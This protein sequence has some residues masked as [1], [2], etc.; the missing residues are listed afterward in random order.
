M[1]ATARC[2]NPHSYHG[3]ETF[4]LLL[5]TKCGLYHGSMDDDDDSDD[6]N[7]DIHYDAEIEQWAAGRQR[8]RDEQMRKIETN[9]RT[10]TTLKINSGRTENYWMELGP[11]IGRNTQLTNIIVKNIPAID[12]RNFARS[13]VLNR[14]IQRLSIAGWDHSDRE[15]WDHL[16]RFFIDNEACK[17]LDLELRC[18]VGRSDE[19][20]SALRRFHSLKEV[21]LS[22]FSHTSRNNG[23]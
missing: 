16:T 21:R 1:T 13:L 23:V 8:E 2:L 22:H 3:T 17:C 7:D 6:D 18:S 14:S 5:P 20:V 10:F 19:M 9:D 11:A 12:F 4:F 15:A